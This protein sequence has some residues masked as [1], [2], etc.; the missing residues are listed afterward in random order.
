VKV[1]NKSFFSL[2]GDYKRLGVGHKIPLGKYIV[3][4]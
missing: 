4:L 3:S 1:G 2:F